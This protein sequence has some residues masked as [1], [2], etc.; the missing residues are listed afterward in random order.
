MK[1]QTCMLDSC[2]DQLRNSKGFVQFLGT[3]SAL[4]SRLSL[5]IL[6]AIL[7]LK[8]NSEYQKFITVAE[9]L[10]QVDSERVKERFDEDAETEL[11]KSQIRMMQYKQNK[12]CCQFDFIFVYSTCFVRRLNEVGLL[13]SKN[14]VG[15]NMARVRVLHSLTIILQNVPL[16]KGLVKRIYIAGILPFQCHSLK[17]HSKYRKH[18][19][20]SFI[21]NRDCLLSTLQID[22]R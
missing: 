18:E 10:R 16:W 11:M 7:F 1:I 4:I 14:H 15:S 20:E 8:M 6:E 12:L 21:P 19:L 22:L 2:S 17:C 13:V 5:T 3:E 9:V